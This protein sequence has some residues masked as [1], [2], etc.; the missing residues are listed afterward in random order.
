MFEESAHA[1]F[2]AEPEK[3]YQEMLKVKEETYPY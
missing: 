2:M 3:F 1:P